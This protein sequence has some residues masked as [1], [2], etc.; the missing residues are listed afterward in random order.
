MTAQVSPQ[1]TTLPGLPKRPDLMAPLLLRYLLSALD[2]G[3]PCLWPGHSSPSLYP[4]ARSQPWVQFQRRA[5]RLPVSST[6]SQ[7]W[8]S[9]TPASTQQEMRAFPAFV[10]T[11]ATS[12]GM[13]GFRHGSDIL[14]PQPR[15]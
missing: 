3:E 8:A 5:A 9:L 15:V 11:E 14:V 7:L 2:P 1:V 12:S 13:L 6:Y 10:G 4:G